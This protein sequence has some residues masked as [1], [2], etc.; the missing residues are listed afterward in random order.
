MWCAG[1]ARTLRAVDPDDAPRVDP[2]LLEFAERGR[3]VTAVA[4]LDALA[5]CADLGHRMARFHESYDVL[6][7]PAVPTVAFPAGRDGPTPE[8]A[9][10][11]ASWTPYTYPFNM[12]R[13]PALSVPCGRTPSGLPAGLQIVGP[14][15]RDARV[16]RVGR[17]YENHTGWSP[18]AEASRSRATRKGQQP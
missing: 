3:E 13:Q 10:V 6:V 16:L 1:I 15:H 9:R 18:V 4:Y 5:V 2:T 7:T 11:W 12:T 17:A 14:R 8:Q